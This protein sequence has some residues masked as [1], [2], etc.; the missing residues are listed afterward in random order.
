M[1]H[2]LHVLRPVLLAALDILIGGSLY[3]VANSLLGAL[4]GVFGVLLLL[5]ILYNGFER[6]QKSLTSNRI[7]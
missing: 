5:H 6:I 1:S 7:K 4:I 2:A 3:V